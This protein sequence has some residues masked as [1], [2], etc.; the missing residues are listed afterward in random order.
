MPHEHI[1]LAFA[2]NGEIGPLCHH[3]GKRLT[4]GQSMVFDQH[5]YC[6]DHYQE[7]SGAGAVT[8][9]PDGSSP[10]YRKQ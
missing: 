2:P 6:W 9:G 4:F 5:Y 3:C 10:F 7:V 1:P 8:K